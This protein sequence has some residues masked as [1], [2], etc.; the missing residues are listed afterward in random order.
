MENWYAIW[1]VQRERHAELLREATR[2]RPQ[3]A[4]HRPL[5]QAR[6]LQR[7]WPQLSHRALKSDEPALACSACTPALTSNS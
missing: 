7:G 1:C 4:M 3:E 2:A 6:Q 5:W